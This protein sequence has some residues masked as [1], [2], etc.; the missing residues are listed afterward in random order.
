M[1][2]YIFAA[3]FA[4]GLVLG[5]AITGMYKNS[6]IKSIQLD[7]QTEAI[8]ERDAAIATRD[9][10]IDDANAQIREF[11]ELNKKHDGELSNAL[12]KNREVA[13]RIARGDLVPRVRIKAP[14]C[15]ESPFDYSSGA[16]SVGDEVYAELDPVARQDLLTL[17]TGL[18]ELEGRV[19]YLQDYITKLRQK[20]ES[21][22]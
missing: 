19:K 18:I 6:E 20:R 8:K 13:D 1:S 14:T 9:E 4:A 2:K 7:L 21:P 11:A 17:R 5:I 16:G 3:F 10:L 22:H 15:P 12:A